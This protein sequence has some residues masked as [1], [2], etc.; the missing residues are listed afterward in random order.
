VE[1]ALDVAARVARILG[2]L[3]DTHIVHCGLR[4]EHIIVG[5]HENQAWLTGFGRASGPTTI[6]STAPLPDPR[7]EEEAMLP[8]A[9]PEQLGRVGRPVD[10]RTDFYA[11]GATL[12]EMLIGRPPFEA[13]DLA[14]LIH[15]HVARVPV[16]PTDCDAEIPRTVSD[17]AMK[18]LAKVPAERYQSAH[19]LR[20]DLEQC[21]AQWRE[22]G[23][24]PGF[25][26]ALHD[27]PERLK[28]PER[29][30]G[31]DEEIAE[32]QAAL[33]RVRDG[34]TE[35]MLV[36]GPAGVGKTSLVRET[37]AA[38]VQQGGISSGASTTS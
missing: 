31:R 9:S 10:F 7:A 26:L 34:A 23:E 3:H 15:A 21:L 13:E 19:G 36:T 11:L 32:L 27:V 5:T 12:Y 22:R 33:E 25:S 30:Y 18:L 38:M 2:E 16:A 8:Y 14:D 4:P 1:G 24:V 17:V 6:A 28:M 35:L 20:A 29:L 37:C